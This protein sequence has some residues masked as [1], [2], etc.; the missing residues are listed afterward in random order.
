M[1]KEVVYAIVAGILIGLI[2][3]FGTWRVSK[4]VKETPMPIAK[5][6][7][8][9]PK[10]IDRISISNFTNY[11]VVNANPVIKGLASPNS[12]IVISTEDD[13]YYTKAN[14]DGEFEAEVEIPAG[15]SEIKI[16]EEKL[17]LVYSPQAGE[18]STSY[19]GTIT[20]I[21]SGNIQIKSDNGTI[22]Q[23][24]A[25]DES[26]YI[27]TLKKNIDIKESDL[28]IGDYIIAIGKENTNKVLTAQRILV[29]SPLT[30]NNIEVQKITIEKLSKTMINDIKLPT[31]WNGPN[32]KE[33]EIGEEIYVAGR[34]VDDKT[35]TL[36]SIFKHVE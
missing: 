5:K 21:S 13:D 14:K 8:L 36:R 29:S 27:N 1:R 3:A 12:D 32:V 11:S 19:V 25:N 26:S 7:T 17:L 20:D 22:L 2:V 15:L 10:I 35:Y 34:R 28:A 23:I 9:A 30:E 24:S 31:K 6:E 4:I 16:N 18:N 33:L